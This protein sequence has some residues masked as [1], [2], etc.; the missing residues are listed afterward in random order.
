MTKLSPGMQLWGVIHG[1]LATRAVGLV[2][3]LGVATAL[4]DG[5][6]P[7]D[8][9]A[10]EAGANPDVVYRLLRA[11]ASEGVFEEREPG[12][13]AHTDVSR[14]L[15]DGPWGDF[16]HLFGGPWHRAAGELDA[17][18]EPSF[19]RVFGTDFW[20]WLRERPSE[21]ASFDRAM[22]EGTDRRVERLHAA[23]WS[24]S[25][26][27][28]DVGGGNGALLAELLR[29]V[30]GLRG[31]VF[32]LPET[33]RDEAALG[34]RCTF[35][36]GSFFDEV[37]AGDVYILATVLHDWDDDAA[38]RILGTVRRSAPPHARVLVLEAVVPPGNEPHGSKWLDLLLL[39]LG[40][41]RERT[42][43]EW[44]ALL[45]AADLEPA[46][47]EDGLVEA[48]CRSR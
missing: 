13:F 19:P 35:V 28:V 48:Q 32:D 5:P 34:N 2:T 30:P 47:I 17:S 21:R 23:G 26:L 45:E 7:A 3:D 29:R 38:R 14:L 9:V 1:A 36:E 33:V 6:R 12:V 41:G 24:G 43:D 31:I 42:E 25:E 11:L 22:V 44:R 37:P 4:A 27:V 10:R 39:A 15:A 8:Q 20:T 16:A 18:G 46:A 40:A